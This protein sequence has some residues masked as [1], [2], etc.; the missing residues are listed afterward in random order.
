MP[1]RITLR[2]FALIPDS[3][4]PLPHA[5]THILSRAN[6]TKAFV[7][8]TESI[9]LDPNSDSA[10]YN[11]G[12][13]LNR[14]GEFSDALMDFDEAVRCSPERADRLVARGL[15]YLAMDDFDRALASFDG[16]IATEPSNAIGYLAR[17]NFYA[18]RGNADKQ[19]R[20]YQ[21]ALSLNPNAGNLWIEVDEWFD[22][23][24]ARVGDRTQTE[25][26]IR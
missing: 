26:S 3:A 14:R 16:A 15:C 21:Q 23:Q 7:D 25:L 13:L 5:D 9:R 1:S 22:N 4:T 12:L 10:Y 2:L 20:D 8:L 18:R 17:S 6:W 19:Q 11:R 24:H